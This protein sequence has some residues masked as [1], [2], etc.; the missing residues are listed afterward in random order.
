MYR[1]FH[2]SW[3]FE[4]SEPAQAAQSSFA[5]VAQSSPAP[6]AQTVAALPQAEPQADTHPLNLTELQ[7]L[8]SVESISDARRVL[9]RMLQDALRLRVHNTLI[10]IFQD[11]LR[12]EPQNPVPEFQEMLKEI[13]H[14]NSRIV[15]AEV[16]EI[17]AQRPDLDDVITGA[18]VSTYMVLASVRGQNDDEVRLR[19]P[20]AEAFV[21]DVY[22]LAGQEIYSQ[23]YL[24]S[25]AS[26]EHLIAYRERAHALI[27]Q[28]VESIVLQR[29]SVQQVMRFPSTVPPPTQHAAQAAPLPI[30]SSTSL[31]PLQRLA[32]TQP[33]TRAAVESIAPN[34]SISQQSSHSS[35]TQDRHSSSAHSQ[36]SAKSIEVRSAH[37]H[38]PAHYRPAESHH[39]RSRRSPSAQY[40]RSQRSGSR[41]SER[42]AHSSYSLQPQLR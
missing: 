34:D 40:S 29:L 27:N 7:N 32:P 41:H 20:S 24:Y 35:R 25:G 16:T 39:S 37:M 10:E 14:W 26:P 3:A 42:D 15:G 30:A 28:C 11:A 33:L 36:R 19:V 18:F 6:V 1:P 23:P 13:E 22:I 12:Y 31:P 8:S 2:T 4:S 9:M 5:P 38:S 21:H 17:R